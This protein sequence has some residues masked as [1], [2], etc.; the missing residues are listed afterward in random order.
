MRNLI[1]AV[2]LLTAA[3]LSAGCAATCADACETIAECAKKFDPNAPDDATCV[4]DC[5]R[6]GPCGDGVAQQKQQD[7]IECLDSIEC[8]TETS[9]GAEIVACILKCA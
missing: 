7:A 6:L 2:A 9:A 5:E 1:A 3:T 8:D 4:A